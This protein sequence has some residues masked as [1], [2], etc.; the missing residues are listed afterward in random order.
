MAH[1][2]D[3]IRDTRAGDGVAR[4][5]R[6]GLLVPFLLAATVVLAGA[7]DPPGAG[8]PG[9]PAPSGAPATPP[10]A[11]VAAERDALERRIAQGPSLADL[12]SY[13]YLS[14]PMVEASRARW[15]SAVEKYRVDTG[16]N[17]P[18]L[19]LEGMYMTGSGEMPAA[20]GPDGMP[21]AGPEPPKTD[22]KVA[23]T[24]DIPLPGR[25]ARAGEAARADAR[26]AKLAVDASVRDL[27]VQIRES[28]HELLYIREARRVAQENRELLDRLRKAGETAYAQGRTPLFDVMKAQAQSGQL[29]YDAQLLEEL[30]KTE[31]TRMN[32]LLSRPPDAEIGPV[33]DLPPR[34]LAYG[35][36]EVHAL[37]EENVEEVRIAQAGVEKAQAMLSMARY[38]NLPEFSLGASYG[39]EDG[40]PQVGV[41]VGFMIPIWRGKNAGRT[42]AARADVEAMRSMKT[43]QVNETRVMVRDAW[44]RLENAARLVRL[45]REDLLPQALKAVEAA[46]TLYRQGQGSFADYVETQA[47]FYSFQLALARARADHGKFLARLEKLAGRDLTVREAAPAAVPGEAA[48]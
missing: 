22:W 12:L 16:W 41:Q 20:T 4:R 30:E 33:A 10:S 26:I 23:L 9:R 38:E 8:G 7:A 44:F 25:L 2:R 13:A 47:T 40:E 45:Y 37:A 31:K 1:D 11:S 35:L 46:E 6:A 34:P 27:V 18:S 29:F 39:K 19:M 48:R 36:P 32:G 15:K 3:D 17:N 5:I 21:V 24:Q 14:S 42:G 43:V 28:Y